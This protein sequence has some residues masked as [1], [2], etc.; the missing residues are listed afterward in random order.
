MKWLHILVIYYHFTRLEYSFNWDT[1]AIAKA[2]VFFADDST[3]SQTY[4]ICRLCGSQCIQVNGADLQYPTY[5]TKE[6]SAVSEKNSPEE[7]G[8]ASTIYQDLSTI[9][10]VNMQRPA[11][12]LLTGC[13][14]FLHHLCYLHFPA[15]LMNMNIIGETHRVNKL[16]GFSGR[17]KGIMQG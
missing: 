14:F 3:G 10:L 13:G 15:P 16:E 17:R 11:W 6:S 4:D 5:H 9:C 8:L 1:R 2:R 12:Y 7:P